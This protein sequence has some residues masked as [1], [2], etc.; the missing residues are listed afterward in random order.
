MKKS[1]GNFI[2]WIVIFTALGICIY[3]GIM[4]Y[5]ILNEYKEVENTNKEIINNYIKNDSDNTTN[6][7]TDELLI[8]WESLLN[9][10]N[11]IIA[12]IQ[13]PG[14]SINYPVIQ[15]NDNNKYL[16]RNI[17]GEYSYGGCIFVDSAIVSPFDTMNT[18]VYGH[19]L[20]N[21]SM[22]SGLKKYKDNE[23]ALNHSI[24]NV[25]LPSGT[26][27]TYKVFSFSKVNE[28]NYDIYNTAVEDIGAYYNQISKYNQLAVEENIDISNPVLTLST[29]TNRNKQERYVVQAY[30]TE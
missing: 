27:K 13:I 17:Y 16:R 9:T 5:N 4:I 10:N 23:Y 7:S 2:W 22:F 12:W 1:I 19:N 14:T 15:S 24:I 29:C 8:D 21:G 18:I 20:N 28:N 26:I 11:E 3:S 30:L 25:Y 6:E